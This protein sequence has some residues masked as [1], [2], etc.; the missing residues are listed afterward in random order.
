[1]VQ[2]LLGL[3][4]KMS[5]IYDERGR[6]IPVTQIRVEPNVVAET[7]RV[8]DRPR[9]KLGLGER[10]MKRTSKPILGEIK[11]AGL[12][13][14][15]RFMRE[16]GIEEKG[17]GG[18]EEGLR[19]GAKLKLAE[20]FKIGDKVQVTGMSKAKGFAG[21]V[22]RWGFKGGPKTHGQSDRERAP[23]SIGRGTTP[24]RVV[25]G[26]KMAGRM[27][28]VRKTIKGLRVMAID[29]ERQ[30]LTVSGQVP[31]NQGGLLMIKKI[32]G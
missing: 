2:G 24:G 18:G 15:P 20:I 4:E 17:E 12:S 1:M 3:K 14:A 11:K 26:Q 21:V 22:K 10:K 32:D 27:G 23:G 29:G 19:P 13:K 16:M 30:V 7:K 8:N 5:Q 25:R 28:G 31:G 9:V 6:R